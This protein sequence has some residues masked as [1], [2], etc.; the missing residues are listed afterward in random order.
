LDLPECSLFEDKYND[1]KIKE[2]MF[3]NYKGIIERD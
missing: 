1:Y 2:E 3:K